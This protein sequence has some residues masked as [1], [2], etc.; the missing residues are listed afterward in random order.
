MKRLGILQL[1]LK[2]RQLLLQLVIAE[3][4]KILRNHRPSGLADAGGGVFESIGRTAS[5]ALSL[6]PEVDE[7]QGYYPQ[8]DDQPR[9]SSSNPENPRACCS[10]GI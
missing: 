5:I 1:I 10:Q 7:G 6:V 4:G 3:P 8:R 9:P 2:A